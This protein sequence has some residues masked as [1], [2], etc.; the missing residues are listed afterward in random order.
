MVF[1]HGYFVGRLGRNRVC[2][3]YKLSVEIPSELGGV[4]FVPM[5]DGGGWK[6][7][8]A[9]ELKGAGFPIDLNDAL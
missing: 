2:A 4:V 5:D 6:L 9:K 8:L 1:E 3:L 7:L